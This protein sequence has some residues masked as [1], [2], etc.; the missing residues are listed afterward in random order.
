VTRLESEDFASI[1]EIL[2]EASNGRMFILMDDEDRENEG[3]LVI[4]A[5]M[6]TPDAIN[7]MAMHGRG[8]ICLALAEERI[9]QLGLP[10]MAPKN[11]DARQTAF[12]VSIEAR[13]GVT[14]GISAADRARTIAVAIDAALGPE[15]IVSPGH[16]FPLVARKG[17]VLV[18]AGHTEAAVDIAR[19]AGLNP[20]GVICEIIGDDGKMARR[21]QLVVFARRHGLKIAT[22]AN[23]IAYRRRHDNLVQA[24]TEAQL[25][26]EF[27]GTWLV[28]IFA[29]SAEGGE[30]VVL[31]KGAV[32]AHRPTL[33]RM[34][35]LSLYA[36]MLG[37]ISQASWQL[38]RSMKAIAEHGSGVIV[39]LRENVTNA[40]SRQLISRATG[41]DENFRD[42]GI[43]A[44]ILAELGVHDIILLT[45]THHN[46][47]GLAGYDL[48]IVEQRP[49]GMHEPESACFGSR[50]RGRS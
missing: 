3:D 20:S 37:E 33:V 10:P 14:T 35:N 50:Y 9:N 15:H 25:E 16:I 12:T 36:D 46:Y 38:P 31:Q 13:D 47:I 43:G 26:S 34:H 22:I 45:N 17:G 18:R 40:L 5:Q 44:Q 49:L 29:N 28:R 2:A 41:A 39:I 30:H 11:G 32:D 27:G 21:E 1:D 42:Y 23:L 24:V 48:S 8:L 4:P 7:F 6:A 19:L